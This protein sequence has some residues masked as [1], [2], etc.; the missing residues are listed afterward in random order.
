[1]IRTLGMLSPLAVLYKYE[2]H[3][4][5]VTKQGKKGTMT[6]VDSL[7]ESLVQAVTVRPGGTSSKSI[8]IF[9]W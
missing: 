7:N 6:E 1:M 8:V 4:L 5:I 3:T 2:L 9:I